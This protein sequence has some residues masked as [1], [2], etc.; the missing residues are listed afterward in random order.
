MTDDEQ[1]KTLSSLLTTPYAIYNQTKRVS[2]ASL[3]AH[4]RVS[5]DFNEAGDLLTACLENCTHRLRFALRR[6]TS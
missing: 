1:G 5:E 4:D 2:R 6:G 3:L